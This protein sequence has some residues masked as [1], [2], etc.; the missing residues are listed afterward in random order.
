MDLALA[1]GFKHYALALSIN[2]GNF[3]SMDFCTPAGRFRISN[4]CHGTPQT[5]IESPLVDA[6]PPLRN[7][8]NT[9]LFIRP[10]MAHVDHSPTGDVYPL[11]N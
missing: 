9:G 8:W 4:A 10:F 11:R 6:V 1:F 3:I 2:Y 5:T 7:T